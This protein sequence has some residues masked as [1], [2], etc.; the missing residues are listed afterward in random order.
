MLKETVFKALT[1]AEIRPAGWLLRQLHIQ[2][3]GQAG[4]LDKI[5]PDVRDSAWIGGDREGWERVPYWLDGF[6]P[7]GWILDDEDMK[8]RAKK[9]IDAILTGQR[10]DGWI[11]PCSDAERPHYD[12]WAAI[13]I[14][15]VLTVYADCS[16]DDR[17]EGA[18]RK[19]LRNLASHVKTF[20]LSNW[21]SSR[22]FEC[23][24]PIYWLYERTGEEWLLELGWDLMS[25]G[26]NYTLLFNHWSGMEQRRV[27]THP[28]HVVNLGMALK[29]GALIGRLTGEDGVRDSEKMWD[30]LMKY[31]SMP[32]GIFSGDECLAGDSPIRGAELCSVVEAMYSYEQI[33]AISGDPVWADR[34][35]R[36]AFNAL[37]AT[38]SADM[39]THQYDQMTNQAFCTK[40]E[41]SP[42]FGTNG[43]DSNLF[44]L[45]PNYG[46]CTANFGQGWPKLALSAFLKGENSLVS[47][48]LV[49]SEVSTNINGAAVTCRLD[50]DYP[51]RDSLT[52]TVTVDRPVSFDLLI[53]IPASAQSAIVDGIS[54]E[55]GRFFTVAATSLVSF[56]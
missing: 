45:E 19:V 9:Y 20:P 53:R 39:W 51:F 33:L 54:A 42:I 46:C 47:A 56:V 3:E 15:K 16:G 14:C 34:L 13:L 24:I 52:Y 8:K 29:C 17:V 10:R 36:A 55:P 30:L 5:W 32:A 40:F 27:W 28:T 25:Q 18:L 4:N 43:R 26:R 31:H 11:C 21:G 7:L 38:T 1:P 12:M 48:V 35:E 37:P 49:P 44:G 22:W 2:A 41:T 23:L 6:I 50:T